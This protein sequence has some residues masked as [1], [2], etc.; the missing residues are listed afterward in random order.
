MQKQSR[1]QKSNLAANTAEGELRPF[2]QWDP[3][4]PEPELLGDCEAGRP[5]RYI[6]THWH[7]T[8][9]IF[10]RSMV[11]VSGLEDANLK[12]DWHLL[13]PFLQSCT[14][15]VAFY[16]LSADPCKVSCKQ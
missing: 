2:S 9:S 3:F 12:H 4:M 7:F 11:S 5:Y 10:E 1:Q 8:C 6:M 13:G 16:V 15:H 14:A